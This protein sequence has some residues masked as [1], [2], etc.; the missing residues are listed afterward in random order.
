MAFGHD[1]EGSG[2]EGA[3]AI[4]KIL[5]SRLKSDLLYLL[6]EGSIIVDSGFPGVNGKVAMLGVSEKGY[7]TFRMKTRGQAG[8]SSMA[9]RETAIVQLAKAVAKFTSDAHPSRF[10]EGPERGMFESLASHASFPF[11]VL[12]GNIWLFRPILSKVIAMSPMGNG[13]VRTTSA[14]TVINGGQKENVIPSEASALINH[15]IHPMDTINTV[16]DFDTQL[17]GD[18][19]VELEVTHGNAFEP[20]PISPFD[21]ESFGYQTI[22]R[23]LREVF[24]DIVVVPGIMVASTDTKWYLN[25]TSNIYRF[26]PVVLRTEEAKLFHGHDE[27]ISVDNYVKIVNYYHHLIL[28]SDEPTLKPDKLVKDEL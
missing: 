25:L 4:A 11:K 3:G 2:F 20:H 9:P 26:T 5:E 8:H 14:V 17:I 22:K 24:Q 27:R 21:S 1:E 10:G 12:Y 19:R 18:D 16:R 23:T 13:L 6:D 28:S 15:R 7:V